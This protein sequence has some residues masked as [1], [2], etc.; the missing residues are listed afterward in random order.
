[1]PSNSEIE[2]AMIEYQRLFHA[3]SQAERLRA[4]RQ[5]ALEAMRFFQPFNPRLVGPVLSGLAHEH[6]EIVLHL[7]CDTHEEVA[8]FLMERKIPYQLKERVYRGQPERRE[9]YPCYRFMA[10]E[11]SI[12]LEVFP[13]DGIRRAPPSPVDGKPM[14]RADIAAVEALLREQ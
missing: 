14:R 2:Q 12:A 6:A 13:L 3:D 8:W 4:L 1:L 9:S 5:A 7:F 10:G 11:E